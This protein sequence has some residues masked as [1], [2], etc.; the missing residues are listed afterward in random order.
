MNLKQKN[1]ISQRQTSHAAFLTGQIVSVS[2][3]GQITVRIKG[4][5]T[6]V[7]VFNNTGEDYAS[8]DSVTLTRFEGDGQKYSI[9]GFGAYGTGGEAE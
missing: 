9:G 8:G 5:D 3:D 6:T 2:T 7:T 4:R 1:Y